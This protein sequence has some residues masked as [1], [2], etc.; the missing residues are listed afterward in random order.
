MKVGNHPKM[1]RSQLNPGTMDFYS[2]AQNMQYGNMRTSNF[3]R[4]DLGRMPN[5]PSPGFINQTQDIEEGNRK[6][7]THR[8]GDFKRGDLG[9]HR[10]VRQ[11]FPG[12]NSSMS[13]HNLNNFGY[14]KESGSIKVNKNQDRPSIFR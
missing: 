3:G 4:E 9:F 6:N 10:K 8:P 14:L 12:K 11:G 13:M 2:D 7:M 5:F 1:I